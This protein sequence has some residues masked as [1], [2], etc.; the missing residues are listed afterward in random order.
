MKPL[1]SS[2]D[3]AYV[4]LEIPYLD[5]WGIKETPLFLFIP[6][7]DD[8]HWQYL[9]QSPS[10]SLY[11]R[12]VSLVKIGEELYKFDGKT[13]KELWQS[14]KLQPP[15]TLMVQVFSITEAEFATLNAEAQAKQAQ[16]LPPNEVIQGI[17]QELGL[18]FSSER[19]RSGFINEAINIAL[20]GRPRALQDKRLS[21]ER[22]DID[23]K[24]AIRLFSAELSFIDSLNPKPDIFVTGVLAGALIMLGTHRDLKEFFTRV[25][26]R[27]GECKPSVEDPVAGLI[28]TIERHR[29]D[30]R[31]MPAMLSIELCRKTVQAVTLWEEGIESPLY[32]RRKLVSG[33]DHM[34]YIREMKRVKHIDGKR[35]L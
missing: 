35:D 17:Y 11:S 22:E 25:N 6:D 3:S 18:S 7:Q 13:R 23:L 9:Q 34:P 10:L 24:K 29:I 14:G 2:A 5:W 30:D 20:R 1:Y 12:L 8:S 27:Q 33:I 28:R 26:N 19:I 15:E 31:A 21:N 16:A 4:L 32:W